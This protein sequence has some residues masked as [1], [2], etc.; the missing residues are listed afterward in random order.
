MLPASPA[1]VLVMR[2]QLVLLG[3][4]RDTVLPVVVGD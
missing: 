2:D 1:L 4:A 3:T